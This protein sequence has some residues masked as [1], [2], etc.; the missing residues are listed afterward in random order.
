MGVKSNV[1]RVYLI[2]L[3]VLIFLGENMERKTEN[4]KKKK[5]FLIIRISVLLL[6]IIASLWS[7]VPFTKR[8]NLDLLETQDQ[9]V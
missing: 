8:I 2:G 5:I 7:W 6:V 4:T 9:N 1:I 3:Y